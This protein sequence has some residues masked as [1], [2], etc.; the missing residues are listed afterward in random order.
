M[1]LDECKS[2][3]SYISIGV[4]QGSIL[5]PLLFNIHINNIQ[6]ST[7]FFNVIIYADDTNLFYPMAQNIDSAVINNELEKVLD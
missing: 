3:I 5:G 4:P 2:N 7:D 1:H 6:F